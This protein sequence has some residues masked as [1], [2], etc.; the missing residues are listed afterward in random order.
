M[1]AI[2]LMQA[3]MSSKPEA[4]VDGCQVL[5]KAESQHIPSDYTRSMLTIRNKS[6]ALRG[7]A[8]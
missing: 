5:S 1:P 3:G 2:G 7:R 8:H 6:D 4:T